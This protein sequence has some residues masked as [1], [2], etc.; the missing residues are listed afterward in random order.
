M[1]LALTLVVLKL[2]LPT[3]FHSVEG[4]LLQFL[5]VVS[6]TMDNGI[7]FNTQF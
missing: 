5:G 6:T 7:V 3:L 1:T 4:V 2:F